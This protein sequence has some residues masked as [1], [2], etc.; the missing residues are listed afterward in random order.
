MDI[1]HDFVWHFAI[2]ISFM[3]R[4]QEDLDPQHWF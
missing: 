3:E 1:S 2:R 4:I